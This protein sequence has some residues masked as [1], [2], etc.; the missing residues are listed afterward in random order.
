[1]QCAG[2]VRTACASGVLIGTCGPMACPLHVVRTVVSVHTR[3]VAGTS[4]LAIP[5]PQ[6]DATLSWS[7]LFSGPVLR[8]YAAFES[9]DAAADAAD[10][11]PTGP[12]HADLFSDTGVKFAVWA[13]PQAPSTAMAVSLPSPDHAVWLYGNCTPNSG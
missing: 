7:K 12:W 10:A 4:A 9:W 8:P 3:G 13:G 1:M 6:L 5:N 2:H 11:Y